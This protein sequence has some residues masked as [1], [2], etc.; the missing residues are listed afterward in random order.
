MY[1]ICPVPQVLQASELGMGRLLGAKFHF[2]VLVP[3]WNTSREAVCI[4]GNFYGK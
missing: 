2:G 3:T 1:R 4:G